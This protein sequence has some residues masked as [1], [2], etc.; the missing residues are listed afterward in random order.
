MDLASKRAPQR[1]MKGCSIRR[2]KK[3]ECISRGKSPLCSE[4]ALFNFTCKRYGQFDELF[5]SRS[6][7]S[8][9]LSLFLFRSF[10]A[11]NSLLSPRLIFSLSLLL[12]GATFHPSLRSSF[13][14]KVHTQTRLDGSAGRRLTSFRLRFSLKIF[15]V[16]VSR[17]KNK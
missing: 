5:S 9:S 12:D 6:T 16:P 10:S 4:A 7:L 3:R 14:C 15:F 17:V 1:K 8:F 2:Q 11:S 13:R